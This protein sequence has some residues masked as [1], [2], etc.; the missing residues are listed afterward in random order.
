MFRIG[1]GLSY[2]FL[3]VKVNEWTVAFHFCIAAGKNTKDL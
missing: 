3:G 1:L 2:P